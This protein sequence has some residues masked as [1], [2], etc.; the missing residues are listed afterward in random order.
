MLEDLEVFGGISA[1]A[2]QQNVISPWMTAHQ[3]FQIVDFVVDD[4]VR[5]FGTVVLGNFRSGEKGKLLSSTDLL[6][7]WETGLF[8]QRGRVSCAW[9]LLCCR[10]GRLDLLSTGAFQ[11]PELVLQLPDLG[12]FGIHLWLLA[13]VTHAG[14]RTQIELHPVGTWEASRDFVPHCCGI[15]TSPRQDGI[16][17][18]WVLEEKI[19]Q[20]VDATV[21]GH[22]AVVR[23]VVSGHLGQRNVAVGDLVQRNIVQVCV[24]VISK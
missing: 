14:L 23:L 21:Q 22:P 13:D 11:F 3:G 2:R 15:S 24:V 6:Q 19:G 7:L 9:Y 1:R 16:A 20:V 5:L 17:L 8:P 18:L 12:Q 10:F 4:H